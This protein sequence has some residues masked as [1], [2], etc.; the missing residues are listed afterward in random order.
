MDLRSPVI[1][2]LQTFILLFCSTQWSQG[3]LYLSARPVPGEPTKCCNSTSYFSCTPFSSRVQ[4]GFQFLEQALVLLLRTR[5]TV[6]KQC[7]DSHGIWRFADAPVENFVSLSFRL[8]LL[9]GHLLLVFLLPFLLLKKA[10]WTFFQI[11][12]SV[13]IEILCSQSLYVH[14]HV[15]QESGISRIYLEREG[16]QLRIPAGSCALFPTALQAENNQRLGVLF[17]TEMC[18]LAYVFLCDAQRMS[19]LH[20]V[21]FSSCWTT[22]VAIYIQPPTN[23]NK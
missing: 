3:R 21:L 9:T 1:H 2:H 13:R 20:W 7:L 23:A 5:N 14:L 22:A 16:Y 11:Q 10:V 19:L 12:T 18:S 17:S 4:L 8:V 6:A 15:F